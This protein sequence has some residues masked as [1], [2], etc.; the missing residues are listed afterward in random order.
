MQSHS[1][2]E[3]AKELIP[4]GEELHLTRQSAKTSDELKEL[5][6]ADSFHCPACEGRIAMMDAKR[7]YIHS[8]QLYKY[9]YK[10]IPEGNFH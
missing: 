8:V 3:C 1:C 9:I 4:N 10:Y 5:F 6:A 2:P 7:K